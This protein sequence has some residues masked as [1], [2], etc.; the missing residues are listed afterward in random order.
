MK[1]LGYPLGWIMYGIYH[2]CKS[3]GLSLIIFALLTKILLLP[4]NLKSQRSA[5]KMRALN[6]KMEKIKKSFANNP[7]R[8]QQE[9][10][11][12]QAD[13]GVN[14]MS[15]CLPALIQFPILFGIVE[16]VYSPLSHILRFSK[17]L[18]TSASGLLQNMYE[19]TGITPTGIL[20]TREELAILKYASD[21]EYSSYFQSLGS[22]FMD[23]I[24]S[25]SDNNMFL[26]F[27]DLGSQANL[28]PEAWTIGAIA[29][30]AIPVLSGLVNLATTVISQIQQ[31]KNNPAAAT[32]GSMNVMMYAMSIFYIWFSF[33][34]PS[35]AAFYWTVSGILGLIQMI[36]FNKY[37]T[38]ERCEAILE[39]DKIKNKGKNKKP[40]FMQTLMEQ[41]QQA[42]NAQ[43][44]SGSTATGRELRDGLS[45]TEYNK[46]NTKAIN[47][48]RR[49][50]AEKY[51]DEYTDDDE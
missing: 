40:G 51:G 8:I 50:M 7:Q 2:L 32:M 42:L 13:E 1:I 41:Q 17:D 28:H 19:A 11:K 26:G 14:P 34:I 39:S 25:F 38:Q 45:K 23:K 4:L 35:G 12:L 29:L 44:N 49:R 24:S 20:K 36:L 9:Q 33:S 48:A 22:D 30:V 5:A 16:V 6:P 15:G 21:P 10:M 31:K 18:L 37:F 46:A 27:I 3:Y 47:E 43:N